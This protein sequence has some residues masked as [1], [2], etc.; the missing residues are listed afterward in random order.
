MLRVIERRI[1]RDGLGTH[2]QHT[3]RIHA[4]LH[5]R[6]GLVRQQDLQAAQDHHANRRRQFDQE[7]ELERQ[8]RG[9]APAQL[10][11]GAE[12]VAAGRRREDAAQVAEDLRR[13]PER[14][15]ETEWSSA[16]RS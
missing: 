16:C 3:Q 15:R 12:D 8:E 13:I 1:Q 5:E 10:H 2:I 7:G 4:D 9:R 6:M 14:I 11:H